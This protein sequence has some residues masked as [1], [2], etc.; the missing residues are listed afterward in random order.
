MTQP[1]GSQFFCPDCKTFHTAESAFGRWI[2]NNSK[3]DSGLGFCVID[4]DYWIHAYKTFENRDFQCLM[5]VEIKTHGGKVSNAQ[6]DTLHILNQ[7]LRNRK[8]LTP[9]KKDRFA[10]APFLKVH[11]AMLNREVNL[12]SFGVFVLTFSGIG[13]EDSGV[14]TWS[15]GD[16][17]ARGVTI[18]TDQLTKLLKFELDPDTFMPIDELLRNHH[19]TPFKKNLHLF[20]DEQAA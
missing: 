7:I 19:Q 3:L 15:G 10:L 12:R 11:S 18:T 5:A 13:P 6:R 9:T 17:R 1:H 2:R 8:N 4:Q 16:G 20:E 14:I